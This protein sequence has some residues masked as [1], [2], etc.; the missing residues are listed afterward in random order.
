MHLYGCPMNRVLG[1]SIIKVAELELVTR[2]LHRDEVVRLT[3]GEVMA[4]TL[5][6]RLTRMP[7]LPR[8]VRCCCGLTCGWLN[9]HFQSSGSLGHGPKW[10]HCRAHWLTTLTARRAGRLLDL[11]WLDALAAPGCTALRNCG[12][13]ATV[14]HGSN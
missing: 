14:D 10:R 9:W 8:L 1:V 4:V 7:R 6:V 13:L 12:G 3:K 2:R 5:P 11:L